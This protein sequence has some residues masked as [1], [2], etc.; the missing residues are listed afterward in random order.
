MKK[1][2]L[3]LLTSILMIAACGKDDGTDNSCI[4]EA[5][6]GSYQG[7][8]ICNSETNTVIVAVTANLDETVG[9]IIENGIFSSTLPRTEI[10]E[11]MA[12]F[13]EGFGDRSLSYTAML[14]GD[15]L[16]LTVENNLEEQK[17]NCSYTLTRT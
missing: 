11:C 3:F 10:E 13:S 5:W 2:I 6:A 14:D 4:P 1:N 12:N 7:E 17:V 8:G 16:T 9:F 15:N